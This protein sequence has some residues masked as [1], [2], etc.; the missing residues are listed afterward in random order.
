M[1][2]S[3]FNFQFF[4]NFEKL[5]IALLV[6]LHHLDTKSVKIGKFLKVKTYSVMMS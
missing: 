6:T 4:E 1:N 2:E 5:T 3:S